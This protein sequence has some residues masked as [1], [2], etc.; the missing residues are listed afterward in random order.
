MAIRSE[1]EKL[2]ELYPEVDF[3]WCFIFKD[4]NWRR[5]YL[6]RSFND[7]PIYVPN[8]YFLCK[9]LDD[10]SFNILDPAG[11]VLFRETYCTLRP[12]TQ[13]SFI[14]HTDKLLAFWLKTK[15]PFLH[16]AVISEHDRNVRW[17]YIITALLRQITSLQNDLTIKDNQLEEVVQSNNVLLGQISTLQEEYKVSEEKLNEVNNR[18][19]G[20]ITTLQE[21]LKLSEEKLNEVREM[22]GKLV[23]KEAVMEE[24]KNKTLILNLVL[25]KLKQKKRRKFDFSRCA[26]FVLRASDGIATIES[27]AESLNVDLGNS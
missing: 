5:V 15:L 23:E 11:N 21:A 13:C 20:Q 22:N 18:L 1:N 19:T 2:M 26:D 16:D 3:F 17:P 14:K 7:V 25:S 10:T 6:S 8:H 4:T 12:S 27:M 9:D 24:L